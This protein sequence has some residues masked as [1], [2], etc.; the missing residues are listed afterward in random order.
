[1]QQEGE[2]V[3]NPLVV[4][5]RMAHAAPKQISQTTAMMQIL[6]RAMVQKLQLLS[7]IEP[8]ASLRQ[9]CGYVDLD[10]HMGPGKLGHVQQ[11]RRG[12]RCIAKGLPAAL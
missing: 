2:S 12:D 10:H 7:L 5:Q 6:S 11:R 4:S 3:G 9:H 1:M 8:N